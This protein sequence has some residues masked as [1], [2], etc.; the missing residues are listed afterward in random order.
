MQSPS[1]FSRDFFSTPHFQFEIGVQPE[2]PRFYPQDIPGDETQNRIVIFEH[3]LRFQ[4]LFYIES[5]IELGRGTDD[6]FPWELVFCPRV[7]LKILFVEVKLTTAE[8]NFFSVSQHQNL[9]CVVIRFVI[10]LDECI[11]YGKGL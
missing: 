2:I 1:R 10:A 3:I 5:D 6:Y 7:V 4:H 9:H 8:N 11:D